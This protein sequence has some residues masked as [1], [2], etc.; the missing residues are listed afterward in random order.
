MTTT[1]SHRL[2]ICAW[3]TLGVAACGGSTSSDGTGGAGG[4]GNAGGAGG[5]GTTC[6]YGGK[7]YQPGD[8]FPADDGCNTCSCSPSGGV[9]CTLMYCSGGCDYQG[10]HYEPGESFT[11]SDGCNTCTCEAGGS[12][13][14]TEMG[15]GPA[16]VYG[17]KPY[18]IGQTFPS[19]D[20][21]N[22]CTCSQPKVV[23]CTTKACTCDPAKEWWKKY[24]STDPGKC[25]LIDYECPE[26]TKTFQNACGCGC[27]QDASCPPTI[28]C[29][30]PANCGDL[31][32]KCPFSGVAY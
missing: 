27:E 3:V 29:M 22:T 7:T 26:N 28:D 15:C 16:C 31:K 13:S 19:M 2:L 18:E 14:C 11:A 21:C 6:E 30:P 8:S 5:G 1:L 20:G 32:K 23:S 12:I 9:G 24:I 17:G 4:S 10:E 25:A